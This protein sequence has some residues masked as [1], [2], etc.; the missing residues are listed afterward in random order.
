M[1][2]GEGGGWVGRGEGGREEHEFRG[3]GGEDELGVRGGAE[4]GG[5]GVRVQPSPRG[6]EGMERG[7][8]RGEGRGVERQVLSTCRPSTLATAQ[9]Q[10][11]HCQGQRVSPAS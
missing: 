2:L 7:W 4:L 9:R 3:G 5:E 6:G 11:L 1:S 8:R 10:M